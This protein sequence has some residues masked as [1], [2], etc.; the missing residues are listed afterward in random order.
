MAPAETTAPTRLRALDGLRG[1]AA[2]VVVFH[3]ALLT[4]PAVALDYIEANWASAHPSPRVWML[5]HTP[6]QLAWGGREAVYLF[7]V[8]SGL[9]LALPVLAHQRFSWLAYYPRRLIRLYVPIAGAVLLGAFSIWLVPRHPA[10]QLGLW[11]AGRPATYPAGS[12]EGD[13]V[14]LRGDSGV[15][16]PLWSLRWEILFSLALPAYVYLL[17]RHRS[18]WLSRVMVPA[19]AIVVVVASLQDREPL[20]YLSTFAVGVLLAAH[21]PAITRA[22]NR[23][24]HSR[25]HV[26]VF[27]SA[28][29]VGVVLAASRPVLLGLG[30]PQIVADPTQW[31]VILG[32]TVIVVTVAFSGATRAVFESRPL[33]WLG[34]ISFSL[35]LVHEPIIIA[36]RY[37]TF[38]ASPLV[39]IALAIPLALAVAVVFERVVE[40][41]SHRLSRRLGRLVAD[42]V[43]R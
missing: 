22:A 35:Y 26:A 14:L 4:V 31:A 5:T 8:L 34:S 18:P 6:L 12:I 20:L 42:H 24:N 40:R 43:A 37:A 27:A 28:L 33:R 23:V 15:I 25:H 39:G 9:V 36:I 2:L 3:H 13:L 41:P 1:L 16:S 32:M 11:L 30:E 21:W 38:P 29:V 17:R 7:F 19:V 10:P